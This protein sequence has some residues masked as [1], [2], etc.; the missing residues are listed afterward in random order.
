MRALNTSASGMYAQELYIDMI[1]NNLA[2]VNTTA[3]KKTR[4]E[5]QDLLYETLRAT[6]DENTPGDNPPVDLQ[7]GHGTRAIAIQKS[8]SQG[9]VALTNNAL[10]CAIKGD[11][12]FQIEQAD[13]TIAYSRDGSFKLSAD[14]KIVTANGLPLEPEIIVPIDASDVIMS[15]DGKVSVL[16]PGQVDPQEIGQI[17]LVRFI[18]P[19]GLS[20]IGQNLYTET[21]NSGQPII[22]TP[23]LEGYG[24]LTQ[25]NLESS[26]V[27]VIEEMVN[28]IAAQRAYEINSKAIKTADDMLTRATNLVR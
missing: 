3:Y 22:G 20:N 24:P 7:V 1:A 5:F 17:E 11:G 4:I 18:N 27:E 25:G 23:G 26:N 9:A 13:G 28:M 21:V 16:I 6:G 15:P 10:D 14:G 19:A 2:N 12:F 8:F